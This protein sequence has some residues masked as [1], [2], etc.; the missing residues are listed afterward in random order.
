MCD[1]S[2]HITP[3]DRDVISL[4]RIDRTAEFPR[5]GYERGELLSLSR[6]DSPGESKGDRDK[7]R[8]WIPAENNY[9]QLIEG[10][11]GD[12]TKERGRKRER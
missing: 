5:A 6:R 3:F 2:V 10:K 4:V 12:E 9:K 11:K 7:N 8:T 1:T